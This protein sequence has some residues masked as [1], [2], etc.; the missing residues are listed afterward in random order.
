MPDKAE[1]LRELIEAGSQEAIVAFFHDM[2]ER[3]RRG[4]AKVATG[5]LKRIYPELFAILTRS[6]KGGGDP[7]SC[8]WLATLASASLSELKALGRKARGAR[9]DAE[10]E[11]RIVANRRPPWLGSWAEALL[12]LWPGDWAE[13]RRWVLEGLCE[14]PDSP[15]YTLGMIT[16]VYPTTKDR[17]SSL[18]EALI[19][20][21]DLLE[22][23]VW[24]LFE[25]EGG[26]EISLAARDKYVGGEWCWS[27]TL[28]GL[29]AS[30][31]LDRGRLLDA[32]LD[33]LSRD[34]SHY[35]AGWFSRFHKLLKPTVDEQAERLDR[36]LGLLASPV[37]PSVKLAL[38]A[39]L[40]LRKQGRVGAEPLVA[41][42]Q[43]TLYAKA[44][45]S[46]LIALILLKGCM[47]ASPELRG[48][49]AACLAAGLEHPDADVQEEVFTVLSV[50]GPRDADLLEQ[51][52]ERLPFIV[53]GLKPRVEEWL[54]GPSIEIT[55]PGTGGEG[56]DE[57]ALRGRIA[58]LPEACRRLAAIRDD[59][60]DLWGT[61]IPAGPVT[62]VP[63]LIDRPC[64]VVPDT[65]DGIM[66][67]F[68]HALQHPAD[69]DAV[70]GVTAALAIYGKPLDGPDAGRLTGPL[71][72]QLRRITQ[73]K[74]KGPLDT[75]AI[76]AR[77]W[78]DGAFPE[79]FSSQYGIV[80]ES[81]TDPY[82]FHDEA[83]SHESLFIR[84]IAFGEQGIDGTF[85]ARAFYVLTRILRHE[86]VLLLST[87][88]HTGAWV[89]PA[90]LV[91]RSLDPRAS[92]S[93]ADRVLA[94]LRLA[95]DAR[96]QALKAAQAV[97]G[98]WGRVLR[99]AL[100]AEAT[101]DGDN[102]SLWVAA[103]RS[104]QP[105]ED[106][107]L[108]DRRFGLLG[109]DTGRAAR[110]EWAVLQER[111]E[112]FLHCWPEIHCSPAPPVI[113]EYDNHPTGVTGGS[114]GKAIRTGLLPTLLS[115]ARTGGQG[116]RD[117]EP[118]GS[119]WA[120]SLWPLNPDELLATAALSSADSDG[121]KRPKERPIPQGY[122]VLFDP[123]FAL[124]EMALLLLAKGLAVVDDGEGQLATDAAIEAVASARLVPSRFG[125]I[126]HRLLYSGIIAPARWARRLPLI[127]GE[128]KL[129]ALFVRESLMYCLHP[130]PAPPPR[131]THTLIEVLLNCC[132]ET[133]THVDD[134]RTRALLAGIS[135][136]TK[137]AR[138]AGAALALEPRDA[139]RWESE[140]RLKL[141]EARVKAAERWATS[142][143]PPGP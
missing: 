46:V 141:L 81:R 41:Y 103:A 52:R 69:I 118:M 47:E 13:I 130:E 108:I 95:P 48:Q 45:S 100:G 7:M 26:G 70:E 123:D 63:R 43:P 25:H 27:K 5:E 131:D 143:E 98:E 96:S 74:P 33:A 138:L 79:R 1:T 132:I 127:A 8:A 136:R 115:H 55:E 93:L 99:Y 32:S 29:S 77:A 56:V 121:A 36:Y 72:K 113:A 23:Q 44:K 3:A 109:P 35:R 71:R 135:G 30:G 91:R 85:L 124:S 134:D 110:L 67:T 9:T 80:G 17:W 60:K 120:I 14:T 139:A 140:T 107:L 125:E 94:L 22:E 104:R 82:W 15:M 42:L 137:L 51:V 53:P 38:D 84:H 40:R 50:N 89:E 90:A 12:A 54:G 114:T 117:P 102:V 116:F 61:P 119:P 24:K 106:D 49:A 83:A 31:H 142:A 129:H 18:A 57:E 66:E 20:S 39:V 78:L 133:G 76:L 59:Q 2:P 64:L 86:P 97:P 105:M 16:G 6:R 19:A 128:S 111:T 34:F 62:V 65:A 126:M 4:F 92:D 73:R 112:H 37:A 58:A 21:P 122:D 88:T 68:Q 10:A 87:P 75:L 28:V 11:F 101:P